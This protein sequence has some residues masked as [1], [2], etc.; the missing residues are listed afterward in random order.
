MRGIDWD[1]AIA[2]RE[3][4]AGRPI[5][6]FKLCPLLADLD[7]FLAYL[8][9]IELA[10]GDAIGCCP[11]CGDE[12]RWALIKELMIH[13]LAMRSEQP[14]RLMQDVDASLQPVR[15]LYGGRQKFEEMQREAEAFFARL[16]SDHRTIIR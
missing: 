14:S 2:A 6:G 10:P 11:E 4:W 12:H 3:H 1:T 5:A 9:T 15:A 16:K 7:R 13:A 8:E